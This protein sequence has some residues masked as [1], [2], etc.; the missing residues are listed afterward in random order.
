MEEQNATTNEMTRNVSE[1]A[2]GGSEISK[3]I[4]GVAEAAKSTAQGAGDSLTA[5][6]SL[7]GM[8]AQLRS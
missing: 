5:S 3:N 7:A 2:K 8:A 6:Q 1:A 4:S